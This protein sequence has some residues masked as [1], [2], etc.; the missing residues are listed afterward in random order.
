MIPRTNTQK[1]RLLQLHILTLFKSLNKL[2]IHT[3]I[4]VLL[5]T[6]TNPPSPPNKPSSSLPSTLDPYTHL[7]GPP[8]NSTHSPP[9]P[10]NLH[11]SLNR[12][13]MV[14]APFPLLSS[15]VSPLT[16]PSSP[17]THHL[18]SIPTTYY[19]P[20]DPSHLIDKTAGSV[21]SEMQTHTLVRLGQCGG[22]GWRRV[23]KWVNE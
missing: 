4:S 15:L 16:V 18:H 13:L 10:P 22:E 1:P 5:F 20:H 17:P 6:L 19:N 7:I 2:S 3:F 23:G 21:G 9:P 8:T 11:H 14:Q 12:L